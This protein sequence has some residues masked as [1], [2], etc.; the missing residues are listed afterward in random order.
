[1]ADHLRKQIRAAI[2]TACTGLTTTG[3]R[4][5]AG[6]ATPLPEGSDPAL[7]IDMGAESIATSSLGG[8]SRLQ[9]RTLEIVIQGAVKTVQSTYL[10]TLDAIALEVE[11]ALA[12]VQTL[13][14]LS[15]WIQP[16]AIDEPEIEGGGEKTVAVMAMHFDVLYYTALNAPQTAR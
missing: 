15:K 14:G 5:Y 4:V 12:G 7:L 11:Q 16:R 10:D 1:M 3:T 6:R 9:E 13:G 8:A 2:V